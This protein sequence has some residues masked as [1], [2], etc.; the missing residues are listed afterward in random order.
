M[1][2]VQELS[3]ASN[4]DNVLMA[5]LPSDLSAQWT[6]AEV[7]RAGI[8]AIPANQRQAALAALMALIGGSATDTV[9]ESFNA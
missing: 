4:N 6:D 2:G 7:M 5:V 1:T 8:S 9:T 3:I